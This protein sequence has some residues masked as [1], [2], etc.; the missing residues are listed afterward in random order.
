[1]A[2]TTKELVSELEKLPKSL[3]RDSLIARA[4]RGDYHCFRSQL[5][6]PKTALVLDLRAAGFED[7]EKRAANGEFDERPGQ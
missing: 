4:Q 1:M 5:E 6:L 7:L 2:T 3:A